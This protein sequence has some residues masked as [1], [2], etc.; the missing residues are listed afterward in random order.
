MFHFYPGWGDPDG[1]GNPDGFFENSHRPD[2][3]YTPVIVNDAKEYINYTF[4]C[5]FLKQNWFMFSQKYLQAQIV[6]FV[7][8]CLSKNWWPASRC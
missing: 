8:A 5:L 2:Y 4:V 1:W 3:P 6:P 7:P